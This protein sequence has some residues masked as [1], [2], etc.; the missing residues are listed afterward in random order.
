[1]V[2]DRAIRHRDQEEAITLEGKAIILLLTINKQ[3]FPIIRKVQLGKRMTD[4]FDMD[5]ARLLRS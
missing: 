5:T 2:N 3:A 4:L 1:M